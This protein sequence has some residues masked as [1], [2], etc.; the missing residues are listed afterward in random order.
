MKYTKYYNGLIESYDNFL[1]FDEYIN[2]FDV[3]KKL[4]YYYGETDGPGY[5][6]NGLTTNLNDHM[7]HDYFYEK[8][9]DLESVKSLKHKRT[10]V[11]YFGPGEDGGYHK[12]GVGR[13]VLFY[14][15]E[16]WDI[17]D[18]GETKFSLDARDVGG[19]ECKNGAEDYPIIIGMAPIPNRLIT[20]DGN[21]IHSATSFKHKG[22]FTFAMKFE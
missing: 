5:K 2:L 3:V 21:I 18:F 17:N 16:P 15:S 13:T 6:P 4:P 11:N 8:V 20:F 10:Y 7:L 1:P 14:F 12:D 19:V 22:R 9:K